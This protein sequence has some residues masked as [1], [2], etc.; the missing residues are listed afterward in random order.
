MG[1]FFFLNLL[2][3]LVQL[4]YKVLIYFLTKHAKKSAK[5][6]TIP[7]RF[8]PAPPFKKLRIKMPLYFIM[9]RITIMLILRVLPAMWWVS[10]LLLGSLSSSWCF[11]DDLVDDGTSQVFTITSCG[12][13][14]HSSPVAQGLLWS[15][16]EENQL[17]FMLM[18]DD[19]LKMQLSKLVLFF[20]LM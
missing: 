13:Q 11:P 20:L 4:W 8:P 7:K 17:C 15:P 2:S 10:P 6:A 16:L 9:C 14:H 1:V 19:I 18:L 3:L 5:Q 12:T